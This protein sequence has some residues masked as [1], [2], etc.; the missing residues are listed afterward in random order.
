M[1]R[2]T[3]QAL[4]AYYSE[5]GSWA[6]G[7]EDALRASRRTAWILAGVAGFL[8]L[9]ATL[10]LVALA[11]LKSV[12]AY[13]LLVDRQTGHVQTLKP[14]APELV[15]PDA[16]LTHAFLAQY[17]VARESFS[18]DTLRAEYRKVALWSADAARSDYIQRTQ[19]ANPDSPLVRYPRSSVIET[20]VK[21][22]SPLD[23]RAA[24]VR[25]DTV[26]RDA[27]GL[28]QRPRAYVAVIRY[29]FSGEPMSVEDRFVNPL[30][31]QVLR[32]RRDIE[33]LSPADPAP[34]N[35]AL[36]VQ[37]LPGAIVVPQRSVPTNP[38]TPE[39][40]PTPGPDGVIMT[41]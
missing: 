16:G 4:D 7:R 22:V 10:S 1:K 36:I 26:R 11:P 5:A 19:I 39:P 23:A 21:S 31:F 2:G 27:G 25:F 6:H 3:R 32:Y 20:R 37:P 29:R 38:R 17:V 15:A 8:A 40:M 14:L 9:A 12:V 34:A 33:A 30:G 13:A 41:L 18:I 28:L 35:P 24:L